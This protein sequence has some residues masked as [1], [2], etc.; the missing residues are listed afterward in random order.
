MLLLSSIAKLADLINCC[1]ECRVSLTMLGWQFSCRISINFM[2]PCVCNIVWTSKS[3]TPWIHRYALYHISTHVSAYFCSI[4]RADNGEWSGCYD[5][6]MNAIS[7]Y[8][9]VASQGYSIFF[10]MDAMTQWVSIIPCGFQWIIL[11]LSRSAHVT[12]D[13]CFL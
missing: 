1:V 11:T 9:K 6:M 12:C 10:R 2:M 7:F 13:W 4:L 3:H 5:A 8:G